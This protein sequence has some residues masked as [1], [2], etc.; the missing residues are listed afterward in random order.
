M[1]YVLKWF[2]I[3]K[4][5][6]LLLKS[7]QIEHNVSAKFLLGCVRLRLKLTLIGSE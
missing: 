7:K 3:R 4:K 2:I 5:N 6:F 1:C